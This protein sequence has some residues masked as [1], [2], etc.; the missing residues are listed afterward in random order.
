LSFLYI[1]SHSQKKKRE[2]ES[3]ESMETGMKKILFLFDVDGTLTLPRLKISREMVALLEKINYMIHLLEEQQ[4]EKT[5]HVTEE[6]LMYSL[7]GVFVIYVVD[8]FSRAGK[9]VR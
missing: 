2:K 6:F 9:Y 7:L 4:M 3:I 5:N 1:H 8:S